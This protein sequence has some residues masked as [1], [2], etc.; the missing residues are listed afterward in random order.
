MRIGHI[1]LQA[2]L[3]RIGKVDSL[4]CPKCHKVDETVH[5][6]LTMCMAY[7]AQ[8][9]YMESHLRRMAKS[10]STLLTNLKAFPQL[11]KFIHNT[12]CFCSSAG[13]T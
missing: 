8:R 5:H 13:D 7:V 1:P 4:T 10:A 3:H 11:F 2:H 6:Y 12:K 9:G